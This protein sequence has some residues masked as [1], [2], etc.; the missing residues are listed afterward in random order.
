MPLRFIDYEE[1]NCQQTIDFII[2]ELLGH[3]NSA[4]KLHLLLSSWQLTS[5]CGVYSTKYATVSICL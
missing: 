3:G 1:R 5:L 4:V 2:G